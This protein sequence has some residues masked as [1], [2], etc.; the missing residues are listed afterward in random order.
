M[1][2][3]ELTI[4][5]MVQLQSVTNRLQRNLLDN[6]REDIEQL[7]PLDNSDRVFLIGILGIYIKTYLNS[8]LI[9]S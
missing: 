2:E 3:L 5:L 7:G 4:S 9:K 6:V 1:D 8:S